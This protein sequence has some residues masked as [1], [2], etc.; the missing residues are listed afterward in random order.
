[1][2]CMQSDAAML[3]YGEFPCR[4]HDRMPVLLPTQEAR[5]AWLAPDFKPSTVKEVRVPYAGDD[6]VWH[7][8]D[9]AMG[10]PSVQGPQ[11]CQPIKRPDVASFFQPR[12]RAAKSA[13]SASASAGSKGEAGQPKTGVA[14][15]PDPGQGAQ[16]ELPEGGHSCNLFCSSFHTRVTSC[17][18]SCPTSRL[19]P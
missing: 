5:D 16:M 8:V 15:K 12:R 14:L 10:S 11:C 9:P 6:L 7:E 3:S 1:M 18:C 4:L 17:T 2:D 19:Q 13:S